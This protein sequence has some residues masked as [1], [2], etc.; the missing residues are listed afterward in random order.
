MQLKTL[1]SDNFQHG[2]YAWYKCTN[3]PH[4]MHAKLI[5]MM[6]LHDASIVNL[7]PRSAHWFCMIQQDRRK[8]SPN[9]YSY[10]IQYS[11]AH[12]YIWVRDAVPQWVDRKCCWAHLVLCRGLIGPQMGLKVEGWGGLNI[13]LCPVCQGDERQDRQFSNRYIA[14][15]QIHI[16]YL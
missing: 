3:V 1:H 16:L 2:E 6:N 14:D 9:H 11:N 15:L 7:H 12:L 4:S 10:V 5:S 13:I 8:L